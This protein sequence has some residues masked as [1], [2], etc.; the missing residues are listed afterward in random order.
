[1]RQNSQML[2]RDGRCKVFDA[3]A[4]GYARGEGAGAVVL[5]RLREAE[6]DYFNGGPEILGIVRSTVTNHNGTSAAY[7]APNGSSQRAL[8]NDAIKKAN[9][10]VDDLVFLE[11]HGTGTKLGDPIEWGALDHVLLKTR[12]PDA[13][14]VCIGAVKT[15]IGH[16]EAAAGM[17]GLIKSIMVL[18]TL[19]G[20]F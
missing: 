2:A 18:R 8:L 20:F 17:A 14:P 6:I 19:K 4:D 5:K 3:S 9:I 15:N 7:T 12:S 10:S 11:T 16:L 13:E 1:M